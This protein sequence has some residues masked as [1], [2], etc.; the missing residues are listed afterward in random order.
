MFAGTPTSCGTSNDAIVWMKIKSP[1]ATIAGRASPSV[2]LRNA[3]SPDAPDAIAASSSDGS[4][5]VN[6]ATAMMNA[7]GVT[8]IAWMKIIP[9]SEYALKI[10]ACSSASAASLS[11]PMRGDARNNHATV[12]RIPG[13]IS[14]TSAVIIPR[15]R[16]GA[17]VRA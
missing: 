12:L 15:R 1:A 6:V 4:I 8:C 10:R 9:G 11:R 7:V 2:T 14:G 3:V 13:T 17:S 16:N 5:D